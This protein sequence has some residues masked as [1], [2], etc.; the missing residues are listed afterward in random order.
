LEVID[1]SEKPEFAHK[2]NII[3]LPTLVRRLPVPVMKILGASRDLD[4]LARALEIR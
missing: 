2:D 1:I 3:I 4:L